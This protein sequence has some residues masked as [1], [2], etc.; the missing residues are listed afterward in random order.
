LI[1]F[2]VVDEFLVLVSIVDGEFEFAFF[3]PKN[4]RLTF[5]AADHVEGSLGLTAQSHLQQVFGNTRLD[6][7]AQL[8]GDLKEAIGRA[9][10]FDALVR[11]LVIVVL[12]PV[13]DTL[14]G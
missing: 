5:H 2:E 13:A 9:E 6:G 4:D 12:D 14:P 1:G 7:F 8:G 3:G 11:T 10:T